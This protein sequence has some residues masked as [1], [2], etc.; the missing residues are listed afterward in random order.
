MCAKLPKARPPATLKQFYWF[1]VAGV[2][3]TAHAA[4]PPVL[5]SL[6]NVKCRMRERE[7]RG[8]MSAVQLE[9]LRVTVWQSREVCYI[10]IDIGAQGYPTGELKGFS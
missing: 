9:S 6:A 3:A 5:C 7:K 8:R 4:E 10:N 1:D 2:R